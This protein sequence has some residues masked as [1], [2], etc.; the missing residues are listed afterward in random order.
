MKKMM[1]CHERIN[2]VTVR[3]DRSSF[4]SFPALSFKFSLSRSATTVLPQCTQAAVPQRIHTATTATQDYFCPMQ[5]RQTHTSPTRNKARNKKQLNAT[6]LIQVQG[7]ATSQTVLF[8]SCCGRI[9]IKLL[10]EHIEPQF[11]F[12]M[13]IRTNLDRKLTATLLLQIQQHLK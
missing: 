6:I 10:K 3:F 12:T 7:V 2:I 11:P 4:P 1:I 8:V 13:L 9:L 5:L